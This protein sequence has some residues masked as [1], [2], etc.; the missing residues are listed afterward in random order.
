[1][2]AGS[3]EAQSDQRFAHV[4]NLT[5]PRHLT[6]LEAAASERQ[7]LSQGSAFLNK[8]VHKQV[9]RIELAARRCKRGRALMQ[10]A[11][12]FRDGVAQG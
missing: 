2:R 6:R 10:F 11:A 7:L 4:C 8:A 9:L 5:P 1:V 3:R 12:Q